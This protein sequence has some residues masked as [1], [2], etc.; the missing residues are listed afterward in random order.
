MFQVN[1]QVKFPLNTIVAPYI[2]FR[3]ESTD[4][5]PWQDA[6]KEVSVCR[7]SES[8]SQRPSEQ[9]SKSSSGLV[10]TGEDNLIDLCSPLFPL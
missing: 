7:L 2:S 8:P 1:E 4:G 10:G 6:W 5:T 9:V 3:P